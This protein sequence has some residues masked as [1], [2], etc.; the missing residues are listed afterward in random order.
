MTLSAEIIA[1][2]K[3]LDR[4]YPRYTLKDKSYIGKVCE[5]YDGD[6][7]DV[8]LYLP[9][10]ASFKKFRIKM[11]GYDSPERHPRSHLP[12]REHIRGK[13]LE[14]MEALWRYATNTDLFTYTHETL[15]R[16]E[17]G[18][19]DKFGRIVAKIY[20]IR[21]ND[22][23]NIDFCVNDAMVEN[24]YGVP[25]HSSHSQASNTQFKKHSRFLHND[26]DA[27]LHTSF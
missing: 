17:C 20:R 23:N 27:F 15:V 18:E 2:L 22:Y 25:H 7:V 26:E 11:F 3:S 16:V 19:W 9:E 8:I 1:T 5:I 10:D 14:S 12:N 4:D 21:D 6:T 24:M 13:A